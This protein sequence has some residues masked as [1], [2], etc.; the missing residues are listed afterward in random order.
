MSRHNATRRNRALCK[1]LGSRFLSSEIKLTLQVLLGLLSS[2]SDYCV[3]WPSAQLLA[4]RTGKSRR[5]I[6]WHLQVIRALAIFRCLRFT[7]DEAKAY[8]WNKYGISIRLDRCSYQAPTIFEVN[9][10]HPIWNTSRA[11]PADIDERWGEI[12]RRMKDHR[13]AK[14]T[15]RLSSDPAQWPGSQIRASQ[16]MRSCSSVEISVPTAYL[17]SRVSE[18]IAAGPVPPGI[19]GI[20]RCRL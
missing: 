9:P 12:V 19:N 7:P 15:S 10:E 3:A 6:Q 13:N 11:L 20:A 17:G 8:C 2:K 1:I 16:D 18:G 4:Q 5:T 14:T